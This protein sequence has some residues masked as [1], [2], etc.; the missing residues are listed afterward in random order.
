MSVIPRENGVRTRRA[1]IVNHPAVLKIVR[2]ANLLRVVFLVR[3]G[4]L[5]PRRSSQHCSCNPECRQQQG[6]KT[7]K[8]PR[9]SWKHPNVGA[10]QREIANGRN[11]FLRLLR[12]PA[13]ICGSC[14]F[15]RKSADSQILDL[16]SEPKISE[17]LHKN[18]RKCAFQVRFLPFAVSLLARPENVYQSC[19]CAKIASFEDLQ[20]LLAISKPIGL[21]SPLRLKLQS[22]SRTR[23]R[24]AASIAF[25]FRACF[26][27]V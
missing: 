5:G 10:R 7:S 16:Q 8:S 11:R 17:N 13:N 21:S 4:P 1:A 23:L 27:G 25:S 15:L 3:R 12:F 2:V 20:N 26:K 6:T 24:I 14:G 19:W 22:R 18:L 9:V